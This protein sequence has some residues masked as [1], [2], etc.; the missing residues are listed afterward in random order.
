MKALDP[1]NSM[2]LNEDE[3]QLLKT[4]YTTRLRFF[5]GVF[6]P[7]TMLGIFYGQRI[8]FKTRS[9]DERM[10]KAEQEV[11]SLSRKQMKYAGVL[12]L[13]LPILSVACYLFIKRINP[14][15]KDLKDGKKYSVNYEVISKQYFPLTNQYFISLND[16]DYLHHEVEEPVYEETAEGAEFPIYVTRYARYVFN[17]NESYT[18]L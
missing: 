16:T 15:R 8:D 17:K 13:E 5:A 7:L 3:R 10:Y 6:F 4:M 1:G 2:P 18:I 14:L 11:A 9:G 12:W